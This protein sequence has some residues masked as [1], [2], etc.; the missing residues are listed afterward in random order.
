MFC[1]IKGPCQTQMTD[2]VVTGFSFQALIA[3]YMIKKKSLLFVLIKVTADEFWR[4]NP[5]GRS[6]RPPMSLSHF[7][8]LIWECWQV[9]DGKRNS[10]GKAFKRAA[11][12]VK[13]AVMPSASDG[14][15]P[16]QGHVKKASCTREK[17]TSRQALGNNQN[18][19]HMIQLYKSRRDSLFPSLVFHFALPVV[20]I[21]PFWIKGSSAYKS[22]KKKFD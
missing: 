17:L 3:K 16:S 18:P 14:V 15:R 4:W 13:M 12:S 11:I 22:I 20:L 7:N 9:L 21:K 8:Q 1:K 2:L 5:P 6:K 10:G 19:S